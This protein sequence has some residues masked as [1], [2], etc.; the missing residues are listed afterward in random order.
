[1]KKLKM[2]TTKSNSSLS[3]K[4]FFRID[5]LFNILALIDVC[6]FVVMQY[7]KHKTIGWKGNA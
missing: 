6:V 5:S 7:P 4:H 2:T 3:S 1:M